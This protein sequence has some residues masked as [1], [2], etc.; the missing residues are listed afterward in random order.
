MTA[1][2]RERAI[3]PLGQGRVDRAVGVEHAEDDA[4][5]A[6]RL[7]GVDVGLHHLDLLGRI[8]EVAAARADDDVEADAVDLRAPA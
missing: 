2:G 8:E 7:G 5:G 1:A 4:V 3:E 6:G